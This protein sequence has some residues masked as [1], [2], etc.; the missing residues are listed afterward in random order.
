[1]KSRLSISYLRPFAFICGYTLL[2]AAPAAAAPAKVQFSKQILPLLNQECMSCHKGSAAGGG[3]SLESAQKLFAGGRHGKAVVP[4]KSAQSTLVKYLT[5]E[6][7]PQMPPGKPLPLD[8]V[9]LVRR[10]IDEGAK[11]D[12]MVAPG[13]PA[14]M[15]RGAMPMKGASAL[16]TRGPDRTGDLLPAPVSQSAPVTALAYSPDGKLLA[17][18]GYKAVRLLDPATGAILHTLSGPSDQVLSV[19]W[20]ADGKRLAAAGG[21]SGAFGE[22]CIWEAPASGEWP[23]PKVLKDHGDTIYGI[24][25][26]PGAAEF[27]TASLDKTVRIWDMASGK[28]NRTLKDHVDAVYSVAYSPDGKWMATGSADR[29]VKL[30]QVENGAKVS[31]FN[32]PDPV[33]GVAFSSKSDLVVA[34]A[35]KQVR[36]WPVKAGTVENPLRGHGEGEAINAIAFSADGS[37]FAWGASNRKVRVWNGEVS[38][39]KREMNDATDWVYSVAVSPDGKQV[40]A[41]AGDGKVYFWNAG[42]GKLERTVPLGA[43]AAAVA[44]NMAEVK[45]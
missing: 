34:C 5:G 37:T 2:L 31:S 16:P 38:G 42:D 32:H 18:G 11:I 45:K 23:R 19:A 33:T 13:Q 30:Y 29:T 20:T 6:L 3:Y 24:A 25:W 28:P 21:I 1:M 27:A 17:A 39:Q 36:V 7:K 35:E 15:M 14:G 44:A 26:R 10:W 9:A 4:G 12:S 41:G 40:A 43:G 22:V 8:V